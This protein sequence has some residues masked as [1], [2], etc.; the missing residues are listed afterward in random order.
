MTKSSS[1]GLLILLQISRGIPGLVIWGHALPIYQHLSSWSAS[2]LFKLFGHAPT[3]G[4][5]FRILQLRLVKTTLES[6]PQPIFQ[7]MVIDTVIQRPSPI[8]YRVHA[9]RPHALGALDFDGASSLVFSHQLGRS[10]EITGSKAVR[11][12][13]YGRLEQPSPDHLVVVLFHVGRCHVDAGMYALLKRANSS[14]KASRYFKVL[15]VVMYLQVSS[16]CVRLTRSATAA[17][18][19]PWVE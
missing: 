16:L 4:Q 8:R 7:L 3:V 13:G 1:A 5:A 15:W 11:V 17:L 14:G 2:F 18:G 9:S 19:S 6:P 10:H 12:G